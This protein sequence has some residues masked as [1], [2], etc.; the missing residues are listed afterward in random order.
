MSGCTYF[1]R[2][3]IRGAIKIGYTS[4]DP[5]ARLSQLQT[6]CP[7]PLRLI[8]VIDSNV[9]LTLPLLVTACGSSDADVAAKNISKA[10]EQFEV[11]RRIVFFN[12]ITDKYLLRD[13]RVL[14]RRDGRLRPGGALGDVQDRRGSRSNGPVRQR[15]VVKKIH[16]S[17]THYRGP[18]S[19]DLD[20]VSR[21]GSTSRRAASSPSGCDGAVRNV[22]VAA[23]VA[24]VYVSWWASLGATASSS[25]PRCLRM[26]DRELRQGREATPRPDG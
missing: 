19:L 7:H 10:A 6:G 21:Q 26:T 5:E 17:T 8:G 18:R 16:V 4:G 20:N 9:L 23:H 14:L 22:C 15:V 25:S 12:G 2:A 1:V 3:G 11:A 24:L 13:R